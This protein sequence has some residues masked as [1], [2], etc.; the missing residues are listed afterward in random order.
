MSI[1]MN[2]SRTKLQETLLKLV[3]VLEQGKYR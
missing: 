3:Y 1:E 2:N